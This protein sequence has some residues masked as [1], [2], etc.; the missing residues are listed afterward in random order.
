M[1]AEEKIKLMC[2][3]I[4]Q[5]RKNRNITLEELS[6]ATGI[7]VKYLNRIENNSAKRIRIIYVIYIAKALKITLEELFGE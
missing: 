5:L 3:N 2:K 4:A 7:S 1:S 6:K